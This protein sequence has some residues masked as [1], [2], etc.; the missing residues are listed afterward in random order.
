MCAW[1]G[2]QMGLCLCDVCGFGALLPGG[3]R[4]KARVSLGGLL[5]GG[6]LFSCECYEMVAFFRISAVAG[7]GVRADCMI[8]VRNFVCLQSYPILL[9]G[10]F[11][12]F[13]TTSASEP[14]RNSDGVLA[15]QVALEVV[16]TFRSA[17]RP[18][19]SILT[20]RCSSMWTLSL[21]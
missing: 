4:P 5:R 18:P 11:F 9:R 20:S 8:W 21:R 15:R 2:S 14:S 13:A 3:T 6:S 12:F 7:R 16:V 10:V 17:A 19:W 1:P